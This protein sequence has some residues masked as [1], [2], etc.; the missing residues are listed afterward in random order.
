MILKQNRRQKTKQHILGKVYRYT[1]CLVMNVSLNMP[2]VT[3]CLLNSLMSCR[4]GIRILE[5]SFLNFS[6]HFLV[7]K[8]IYALLVHLLIALICV[9]EFLMT[10]I[11]L[12]NLQIL[13]L[14]EN[15]FQQLDK[16]HLCI[17]LKHLYKLSRASEYDRGL[18]DSI[19]NLK[20]DARFQVIQSLLYL[21]KELF[22]NQQLCAK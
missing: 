16:T 3:R 18:V 8:L 10:T 5:F 4:Y 11:F 22:C 9:T 2:T 12:F 7:L 13:S 6:E 20:S 21:S 17:C 19:Q 15:G 1:P 14:A